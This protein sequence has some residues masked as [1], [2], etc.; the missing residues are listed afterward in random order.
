MNRS[1]LI[2]ADDPDELDILTGVFVT[3]GYR[4][5]GVHHPRRALEAAAFRQFHVALVD[6]D[7]PE[8]DGIQLLRCL[9]RTQDRAHGIL[10]SPHERPTPW[11]R[12]DGAFAWIVKPY[13]MAFLEATVEDACEQSVDAML[14]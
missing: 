11:S 7:L 13:T 9:K 12:S 3:A 4:V 8:I 6:A 2:V 14:V 1:L 10:L 5:V